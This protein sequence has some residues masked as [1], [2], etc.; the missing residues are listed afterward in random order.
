MIRFR[1]LAARFLATTLALSALVVAGLGTFLALRS[2]SA[3]RASLDSKGDAVSS[4]LENVGGAYLENFDYIA[5]D[6]L[7]ADVKRDPEVAFAVFQDEKGKVLTKDP[8]PADVSPYAVFVHELRDRDGRLMG[9]TRVGYRTEAISQG[10]RAD[11]FAATGAALLA[12]AVF[13]AGV[14]VLV[15]GVTRPLQECVVATERLAAGDLEVALEVDR[16][17]E[18]GRLLDG[19]RTMLE[20]LRDVVARVQ[21]AADTVASGSRQ[22]D[23]GA[24]QMSQGT[25]EQAAST[26]EASSFVEEMNA[27]IRQS[28]A[29]AQQTERIAVKSAADAKESGAAVAAAVAAMKEIAQKIGIIEEIAYQT[30]LLAL[31]AAIEAARAG[32][33]G[34]GFAVVA[35]E[36]RK[37]AE[38]SQ[39]AAQEIGGLA[40][41]SVAVAEKSG[42]LI[43][44]LVPDIQRTSELVQEISASAREQAT[45]ADQINAAIQQLN[46]VVQQNASAA[47]EMS[48]T[49]AELAAQSDELRRLVAFF[50][51]GSGGASVSSLRPAAE[52]PRGDAPLRGRAAPRL[53]A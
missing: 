19:M 1:S 41:S 32:D 25:A 10:L 29:N 48:S 46:K 15:R 26:E 39:R 9:T 13:A 16:S 5:L 14:V 44:T 18:L 23:A 40:G 34:K 7:V 20:R 43:T 50:R 53:L 31:N 42:G 27:A 38:R 45:N 24:Q 52:P 3:I 35:T 51:V 28:A 12:L 11:A 22:I 2:A 30:N 6:R 33:H 8:L 21:G 4:L 49:A 17:D 36:V 47:E 37:L